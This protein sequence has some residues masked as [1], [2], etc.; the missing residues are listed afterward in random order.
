MSGAIEMRVFEL[1][2]ARLCHELIGPVAAVNNGAEILAEGDADFAADA[3]RL[4][5]DSARRVGARLQFYRFAYGLAPAGGFSGSPPHELASAY[6]ATTRITCA[7]HES[8]QTLPL[9]WQKFACNLLLVGAEALPRGGGLS[10]CAAAAGPALTIS[11]GAA[12]LPPEMAAALALS[13][14]VAALTAR[15]VQSYFTGLLARNLGCRLIG[16][17]AGP[18]SFLL[19]AAAAAD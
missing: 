19:A 14:P 13:D 18:G 4:I 5:A 17:P 9:A 7:Y 3:V 15:T 8:A 12:G 11:G 1:L 6:F 16:T 2:T 10:L